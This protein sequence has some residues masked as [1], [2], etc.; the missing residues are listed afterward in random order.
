M[1]AYLEKSTE[2]TDFDEIVDFL[3]ANPIR[4]ALTVSPTI[5]VSYIEQFWSIAKTKTIIN[6]R[7]IHAKVD[8]K[9]IV[10]SESYVMRDLQFN[11]EDDE[12]VHEERED[13]MERAATTASSLEAEQD[14]G[15]IIRTQSMETLNEHIPQGTGSGSGPRCQ[16]TILGDRPAQTRFESLSKQ[17]NEPPLSRVNILGSGE[18][19]MKLNELMEIC[20][21]LSERVL[22]L[23]NIKTTQDLKITNLKKRVKKLKKK[24]KSRTPQLKMRLFKVRIESSAEKSLGDQEDASKKGRNIA[25]FDTVEGILLFKRMQRIRGVLLNPC[26]LQTTTMPIEDEDLQSLLRTYEN[27]EAGKTKKEDANIAEWDDVQ[28]MMDANYE[29]ATRLQAED[30]GELTIEEM[31][32]LFV[33]LIDER[34][35][36]FERLKAEEK[37]RKPPTKAQKRNQICTYLKNMVGFTHKHLMNKSFNEIHKAFDKTMSWINSFVPMDSE[38]VEGSGKKAESS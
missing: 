19:S 31:S 34:K 23:E 11:D 33:E 20:T 13:I 16:D 7:Q 1:V 29:L 26:T 14:S 6:E 12:T 17:S 32:R 30:Q 9:T 4:Y 3:N 36:H 8:G 38:V 28:A 25:E 24:K 10:I 22:A 21:K 35:R 37:R 18:D 2:N 5:Y 15:N 27:E